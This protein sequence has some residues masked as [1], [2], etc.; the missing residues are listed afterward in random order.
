MPPKR[1]A[2]HTAP[3]PS[4]SPSPLMNVWL[5]GAAIG[6]GLLILVGRG[7]VSWP[8]H[9]L[10]AGT[11]TLAGCLAL[12]GPLVLARRGAAEGGLGDLIWMTGGLLVWAFD[13]AAVLRG[14]VRMLSWATPLGSQAM[15]LTILAVLLAGWRTR[16]GTRNWSWTN[17]TGWIL[18][19]VWVGLGMAALLP[20]RLVAGLPPRGAP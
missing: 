8:P 6:Y 2:T 4:A 12:V 10:L 11:Y 16:G 15:G 9:E 3:A 14:E 1:V 13:L 20:G 18:G 7:R 19:L 5:L 17:V